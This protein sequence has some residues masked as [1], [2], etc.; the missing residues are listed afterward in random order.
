MVRK[1]HRTKDIVCVLKYTIAE[2]QEEAEIATKA[3]GT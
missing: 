3:H 1:F 2:A